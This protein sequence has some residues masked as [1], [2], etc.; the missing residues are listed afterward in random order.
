[1]QTN[2]LKRLEIIKN[3][4]AMEEED[5]IEMQLHK[6]QQLSLNDQVLHIVELIKTHQYEDVIQLIEQY[7]HNNSGIAVYE[8]PQIQGLKLQLKVLEDKLNSLTDLKIDFE[9]TINN[10]NSEYTIR[11]GDLLEEILKLR[12]KFVS[13]DKT[14]EYQAAKE[15]YDSYTHQHKQQLQDLSKYLNQEEKKELKSCYRKASRLCHPDKLS[16]E[17]KEQ[18]EVLF[19]ALNEAYRQQDLIQVKEILFTLESG[20]KLD[21]ASETI[22]DKVVL[23]QKVTLLKGRIEQ[24]EAEIKSIEENEAYL[25][26]QDIDD[27][28]SYFY[29][30]EKAL[31]EE[32][33][34]L[35]ENLNGPLVTKPDKKSK[36]KSKSSEGYTKVYSCIKCGRIINYVTMPCPHCKW[37]PETPSNLACSIVLSNPLIDV[38]SL[39]LLAREVFNGRT[40]QDVVLDFEKN[41]R[42]YYEDPETKKQLK[43][44]FSILKSNAYKNFPDTDTLRKCKHCGDRIVPSDETECYVCHNKIEWHESTRLLVCID[45]LM[46]LFEQRVE[47]TDNKYFSELV[48][49]MVQ[50]IFILLFKKEVPTQEQRSYALF[51]LN[52][53][54]TIADKNNGAIITTDPDKMEI[55]LIEADKLEDSELFGTYLY[56]ELVYF[57]K[58]MKTGINSID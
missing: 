57:S 46:W 36:S 4:I 40:P 51:L 23:R 44:L 53:V 52:K 37:L 28:D 34:I 14:D 12:L 25:R 45:N 21:I 48:C 49:L 38:P 15:S 18:G 35:K 27:M 11:L 50:M 6:L 16:D 2:L 39:L 26:I 13:D 17:F 19:K 20:K 47:I 7:K 29:G 54:K 56:R 43:Q 33:R 3:A 31:Q 55:F 58:K 5:L 1:M 30:L 9:R 8:D 10:F 22:D 32:L 42:N 24:L 41:A